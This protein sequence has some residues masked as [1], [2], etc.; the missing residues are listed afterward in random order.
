MIINRSGSKIFG[1]HLSKAEQKAL[2]IEVRKAM[3][4]EGRKYY[5]DLD[6]SLLYYLHVQYGWGLKRLRQFWEGFRIVREE[7]TEQYMLD[8]NDD[9][10]FLCKQ[11]LK[12]IGVLVD[13]W[14]DEEEKRGKVCRLL[15]ICGTRLRCTSS[16]C[17]VQ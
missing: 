9:V 3:V 16:I 13:V 2:D 14:L 6:A 7:A 12:D 15:S 8:D 17:T 1:A 11:K 4:E 5:S 10:N